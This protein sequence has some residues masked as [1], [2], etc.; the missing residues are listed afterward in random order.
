MFPHSIT[1]NNANEDEIIPPFFFTFVIAL[2]F[3]SFLQLI[4][5]EYGDTEIN[6]GLQKTRLNS[7]LY[8]HWNVN[9]FISHK[10]SKQSQIEA[11]NNFWD[12]LIHSLIHTI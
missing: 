9:S 3:S 5:F 10:M 2:F 7:F 1:Q 11:Y 12:L 6:P 8:S 4:L